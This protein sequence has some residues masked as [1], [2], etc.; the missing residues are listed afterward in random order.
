VE[1][2]NGILQQLLRAYVASQSDRET[3]LPQV[4]YAYRTACHSSTKVSPYLLL[5]GRD[6]PALQGVSQL[7]YD[8]LSYLAIIQAKLAELQDFVH[9]NIAEAASNAF[10]QYTSVASFKQGEPLWLSVPTAGKLE[11]KWEGL[12]H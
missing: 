9:A 11:P 3:Y 2:F 7:A 1:R 8:S 12:S 5:Y 10:N 6:P 4:L